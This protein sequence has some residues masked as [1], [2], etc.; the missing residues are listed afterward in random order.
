[1]RQM[2]GTRMRQVNEGRHWDGK[3]ISFSRTGKNPFH[4]EMVLPKIFCQPE[5]QLSLVL[6]SGEVRV[7]SGEKG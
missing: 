1:M 2:A 7:E 6:I 5:E 3:D 4:K